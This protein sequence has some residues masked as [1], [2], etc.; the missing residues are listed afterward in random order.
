[1][2]KPLY[3]TD[4]YLWTQRMAQ[5]VLEGRWDDL[6]RENVA[7][8]V[9]RL[10]TKEDDRL[11]HL[12]FWLVTQLTLWWAKPERRCGKWKAKILGRRHRLERLLKD[13]PSLRDGTA[14]TIA[15]VSPLAVEKAVIKARLV[16]N[17]Y[18]ENCS[19]TL[20]QLLDPDFWPT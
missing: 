12:V 3:D 5:V 2:M 18:P 13:S 14:A 15:E 1:M 19:F 10:G 11:D 16:K 4:F 6:D 20:E 8:Q 17:P 7:D 9:K